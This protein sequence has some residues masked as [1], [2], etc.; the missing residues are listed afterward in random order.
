MIT[1]NALFVTTANNQRI[2][3]SFILILFSIY[4]YFPLK[5]CDFL[6]YDD[7]QYIVSNP[8]VTEGISLKSIL[9]AFKCVS[10]DGSFWK[11]ISWISHMVDCH[12]F[13]LNPQW[14]HFVNFILHVFNAL[15][16]LY[17]LARLEFGILPSFTVAL[18]FTTHPIN[19]ESVAWITERKELLCFFFLM[20]TL[21]TYIQFL[22][23]G[24]YRLY[25][26]S[27]CI[28]ALA[29]MSKPTAVTLPVIL[30]L[31]DCWVRSS[32]QSCSD[33][34]KKRTTYSRFNLTHKLPY[35]MMAFLTSIIT[36]T[37]HKQT[38]ALRTLNQSPFID[39]ISIA[40]LS[41]LSYIR[42]LFIPTNFSIYYPISDASPVLITVVLAIS[43]LLLISTV[44]IFVGKR[45][46]Y[47][48]LTLGWFWFLITFS[49]TIGIIQVSNQFMANRYAY[50]PFI[51]LFIIFAHLIRLCTNNYPTLKK[52]T[53]PIIL[54]IGLFLGWR[55]N[56][57][58]HHWYNTQT[59]FSRA[60]QI[61]G[62]NDVVLSMLGYCALKADNP[63]EAITYFQRS[64][65]LNPKQAR[66][67]C[68]LARAYGW[69]KRYDDVIRHSH[70]ALELDP[71]LQLAYD[72][73]SLTYQ[74]LGRID[75]SLSYLNKALNSRDARPQTID[76]IYTFLI[77][78]EGINPAT[79]QQT[80]TA[81]ENYQYPH[82]GSLTKTLGLAKSKYSQS[83]ATLSKPHQQTSHGHD[84]NKEG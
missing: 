13:G 57:E 55:T 17:L 33:A 62:E 19:T 39:R 63:A 59:L 16:L 54:A 34:P 9:W 73:L 83:L 80:I 30:C 61:I 64:L 74:K 22:K 47:Q 51:G 10:W 71:D 25:I 50:L 8:N 84:I 23:L 31:L 44:L 4:C 7:A 37:A 18:L 12:L 72:T 82:K 29:L 46:Q 81:L 40:S 48:T 6:D 24:G 70:I 58:T 15:L 41:C 49:P 67:H 5:N 45:I 68:N 38:G 77:T 32:L 69:Y 11:P 43:T 75:L 28:Y 56:Q 52:Y 66:A 78:Y 1:E 65:D 27:L 3:I 42:K 26:L 36:I 35:L 2:F 79:I 53:L 76:R 21:H 20:I 60:Y 14:H